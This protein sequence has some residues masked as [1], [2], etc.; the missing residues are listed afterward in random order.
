VVPGGGYELHRTAVVSSHD[1]DAKL[2]KAVMGQGCTSGDLFHLAND[3]FCVRR[4][5]EVRNDITPFASW[6]SG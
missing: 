1:D 4:L 2:V 3:S 5:E 6:R